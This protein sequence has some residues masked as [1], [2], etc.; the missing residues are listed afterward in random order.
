MITTTLTAGI[1]G[2]TTMDA[3]DHAVLNLLA[4]RD[5]PPT[6]N[7]GSAVTQPN[8]ED[9]QLNGWYNDHW[10]LVCHTLTFM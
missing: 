10:L 7:T 5:G 8:V 3:E 6:Q 2:A 9:Y 1:V 4:T